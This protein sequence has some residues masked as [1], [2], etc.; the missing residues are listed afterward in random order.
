MKRVFL[1]LATLVAF[2]AAAQDEKGT[3][4]QNYNFAAQMAPLKCAQAFQMSR[5]MDDRDKVSQCVDAQV[6][7]VKKA[8]TPVAK[9]TSKKPK[10]QAALKEHL[11]KVIEQIKGVDPVSG[12]RVVDYERRQSAL[13]SAASEAWT[14]F[15]IEL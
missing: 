5:I 2:S 11:V 10:A 4:L 15:E 8:Y 3:P 9:M 13:K 6:S 7:E 14:R 12:E 1:V